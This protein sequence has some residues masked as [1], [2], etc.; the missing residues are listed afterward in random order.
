MISVEQLRVE[1]SPPESVLGQ[2][3]P[4]LSWIIRHEAGEFRQARFCAE[5]TTSSGVST[6]TVA[7]GESVL[8]EWPFEPL[9]SRE[10]GSVRVRAI[11][12]D[13]RVSSWS[14]PE[15]LVVGLL[16]ESDWTAEFVS[17][18]SLGG[19]DAEAPVVYTSFEL[20]EAP[21]QA[22]L[23]V[24]A[25]GIYE[26]ELNGSRIG[27]DV[28][29]P[30]WTAY[31]RRLRY[32]SYDVTAQL[33]VGANVLCAVLGNGWYRGQLV[34]SGNRALYGDRLALLAQLELTFADGTVRTV[35]TD[36]TWRAAPTGI[37]FD[38]FYDGERR[39][40]RVP[41]AVDH[42]RSEPVDVVEGD[43]ARLL[44]RRGPAVREVARVAAVEVRKAAS[45]RVQV[46]FGQNLVGWAEVVVRGRASGD[47]VEVRHAEVLENGELALRPLRSAKA[48][49]SYICAG[50]DVEVLRPGFTFSGFRY[51]DISGVEE[52]DV[53]AVTAIVLASDL[54]RIGWLTTSDERL[55]RLH[56]NV[57]WSTRGNF[58][59]LPTDC[60]Q[61]DERLGWTGDI[62]V[63]APTANYLFDT[64]GFLAGWL[65]DLA[66]EQAS[67]GSV[68]FVIPDVL[69]E[70]PHPAATGWGDAAV[71]VPASLHLAFGDAAVLRRQYPSMRGWVD[72]L[73]SLADADH[74]WNAH[75][76]F[77]DWLDPSAPPESPAAAKADQAV[78]ATAYYARS[79]RLL[80]D[81][82][83]AIG[84]HADA[85]RYAALADTIRTG[86]QRRFVAADGIVRSDCQT[87]YA[88]ALCGD[89]IEDA[90]ARAG[91]GRRLAELVVEA[92][93]RVSTGFLGTPAIL[94]A[95]V[96]AGRTD[97]AYR[98]L[99]ETEMPSWLYAVTMGATTI[100]ERWDSMLPDGSVNPGS[101]T[102]FNHYAYGAVA[103]WMHRA[104][105][106]IA[107]IEPGY[108]R[109]EV[110]PLVTHDLEF[111]SA[112]H[113]SPYGEI[114]VDWR[115]E[116]DA[117]HLEVR[118]PQGSTASVWVPGSDAAETVGPGSHSWVGRLD[119]TVA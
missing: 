113:R 116:H 27:D 85:A 74:V 73:T 1:Q 86:F 42:E 31:D 14:E 9:R 76:Q 55:N 70:P 5:L 90:A 94:D 39:D 93:Y 18:Q 112:R 68:P 38:D 80:A 20:T 19:L 17:P 117:V 65:E 57:V 60:P 118:V 78:V 22:R 21:V 88:L 97:L 2:A 40:L 84:E 34:W 41:R 69:R 75:G 66:A 100:W 33:V 96:R 64:A 30:G 16:S 61:R 35:A 119:L 103:D 58:L 53:V 54:D 23:Y 12:D 101:M 36:R 83:A 10:T 105:G 111:A 59:D 106:G 114:A 110:R 29:A 82:A 115:R 99:L 11:A 46:D 4:R 77:G 51:I 72:H 13:G 91:A 32:Q 109:F 37:L 44:P 89:L 26:P 81:A 45:G 62:Q 47:E 24:T 56:E 50:A 98:M 79:A 92:G 102:S 63:F 87:V 28:L 43:R 104:I 107:P 6:R 15:P 7:S 52:S 3:C 95:L 67:D 71:I 25:H 49:C 8:V 108:R 48:T